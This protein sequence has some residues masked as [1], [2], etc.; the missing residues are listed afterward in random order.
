LL[1]IGIN[2]GDVWSGDIDVDRDIAADKVHGLETTLW[3][4]PLSLI[5][6]TIP[7]QNQ[8]SIEWIVFS[9][10]TTD[11]VR[12]VMELDILLI[13]RDLSVVSTCHSYGVRWIRCVPS[14]NNISDGIYSIE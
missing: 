12:S 5:C 9:R 13:R 3:W 8:P 11:F 6:Y 10:K 14:K 2:T 1:I 4:D 7:C